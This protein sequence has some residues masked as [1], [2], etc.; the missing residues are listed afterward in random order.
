MSEELE[1]DKQRFFTLWWAFYWR[2]ALISM[3]TIV[4]AYLA[5]IV[6]VIPGIFFK[7]L[8]WY[9][10]PLSL[11]L[12]TAGTHISSILAVKILLDKPFGD[13]RLALVRNEEL[14]PEF[15]PFPWKKGFAIGYGGI[16]L[17]SFIISMAIKIAYPHIERLLDSDPVAQEVCADENKNT[18]YTI[19]P[20]SKLDK[21]EAGPGKKCAYYITL[22]KTEKKD[23]EDLDS[24]K[25]QMQTITTNAAYSDRKINRKL[26]SK[27]LSLLYKYHD[28]NGDFLFEILVEPPGYD[29]DDSDDSENSED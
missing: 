25:E 8:L 4:F 10:V 6:S 17:F 12:F 7:E 14:D 13:F 18:P 26:F 16:F 20:D 3:G 1:K 22:V 28:K 27:G 19:D 29:S 2:N 15:K 23:I 5:I 11:T 21:V 24:W 9:I